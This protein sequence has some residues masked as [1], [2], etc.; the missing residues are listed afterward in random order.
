LIEPTATTGLDADWL[1]VLHWAHEHHLIFGQQI[2]FTYGP[3]GFALDGAF[4]QTFKFVAAFWAL[5]ALSFC[6]GVATLGR[7]VRSDWD[8]VLWL[9]AVVLFA[10]THRGPFE[11]MRIYSLS[12]LLLLIHFYV[13]DRPWTATKILLTVTIALTSLVKFSHAIMA[14]PVLAAISFD[15]LRRRKLP[16]FL[17]I[18]IAAFLAFWLAA[19]QPLGDLPAYL[20]RSWLVASGYAQ[21]Q[22]LSQ[23]HKTRDMICFLACAV[24]IGVLYR[25]KSNQ[26][27]QTNLLPGAPEP[28]EITPQTAAR[29]GIVQNLIFLAGLA[30]AIFVLFKAGYIRHD[31][32]QVVGAC[33]LLLLSLFSLAAM[34]QRLKSTAARIVSTLVIAACAALT[35]YSYDNALIA[36][37]FEVFASPLTDFPAQ[38]S[39]ALDWISGGDGLL[40]A[41]AARLAALRSIPVPPLSGTV[42][43]YPWGQ[44]LLLAHDLDYDPRP[45]F[46]SY[47]AFST[48]LARMNVLFLA[49]PR[50]PDNILFDISPIDLRYPSEQD[51]L[52]WPEFFRH[53]DLKAAAGRWLLLSRRANSRDVSFV[54]I[55]SVHANVLQSI[56]V[57]DSD[58]PVWISFRLRPTLLNSIMRAIYK[59]PTIVLAVTTPHEQAVYRLPLDVADSG[60]LLSPKITDRMAFADLFSSQWKAHQSDQHV[61]KIALTIDGTQ[62][63]ACFHNDFDV[64]FSSLKF[65]HSLTSPLPEMDSY[66]RFRQILR[67]LRVPPGMP[68]PQLTETTDR[69]IALLAPTPSVLLL[70]IPR[71]SHTFQFGYGVFDNRYAA[72]LN[73]DSVRFRLYL[74]DS[75]NRIDLSQPPLWSGQIDSS[76][77]LH[78]DFRK[79]SVALPPSSATSVLVLQTVLPR[80]EIPG[81]S[82]WSDFDF[83]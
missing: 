23:L 71:G 81:P 67:G 25:L 12:W 41:N 24:S 55:K 80:S 11:D 62:S 76:D 69:Q 17:L 14:L 8:A 77:S 79:D 13:D 20:S 44:E 7:N 54:P 38:T 65:E 2:V 31:E 37:P 30:G 29:I 4:P 52:S 1:I 33:G 70:P 78:P 5:V 56:V 53:Y 40:R 57:P 43:V 28:C 16:S 59:P 50:A 6:A 46:Q 51:G 42:D 18:Y 47:L 19:Q 15:Q 10:A 3:W 39:A 48:P 58:D 36:S 63:S 75:A 66:L 34:S 74:Q 68:M 60:F 49:G 21:G 73:N 72:T 9:L 83:R 61:T 64:A 45:V 26:W 32:H 22:G 82:C 27:H 35:W